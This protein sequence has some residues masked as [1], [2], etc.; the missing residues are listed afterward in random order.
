MLGSQS[1]NLQQQATTDELLVQ[2]SQQ[3]TVYDGRDT[4]DRVARELGRARP[5]GN[6]ESPFSG[7]ANAP[8]ANAVIA[9][10]LGLAAGDYE[11]TVNMVAMDTNAV[12]RGM[13]VQHRNAANTLTTQFLGGCAA[14]G[15]QTN[16]I[17]RYTL[18]STERVRVTAGAAAGAASSL[19]IATIL[20][21]L[22][23]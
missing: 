10:T 15:N 16:H 6:V 8:A 11:F 3:G 19:Y 5:W 13:E 12:G 17:H 18:A 22:A 21:R 4:S 1:V 9:D 14:P 2:L 23:G 7:S 20:A